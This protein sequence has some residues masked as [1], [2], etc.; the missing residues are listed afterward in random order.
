VDAATAS[1]ANTSSAV[2]F[3]LDEDKQTEAE[4]KA[5]TEAVKKAKEKAQ[6]LAKAAGIKLGRII[7]ITENDAGRPIPLANSTAGDVA[8]KETNIT[9]GQNNIEVTVTVTYQTL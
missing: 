7:N 1:G 3:V 2:Q 9:P 4:N 5:R 8:L 6:G